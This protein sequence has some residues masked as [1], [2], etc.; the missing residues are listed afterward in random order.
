MI[1]ILTLH[2]QKLDGICKA[3]KDAVKGLVYKKAT[4][5]KY[6]YT[7]KYSD[8]TSETFPYDT[9]KD[10]IYGSSELILESLIPDDAFFDSNFEVSC[11]LLK[12]ELD[13][14]FADIWSY[15]GNKWQQV[16]SEADRCDHNRKRT[17][18]YTY[19]YNALNEPFEELYGYMQGLMQDFVFTEL[20]IRTCPYCNRQYTFTLKPNQ[21]G[22]PNT[23][24]EFD[25]FYPKS[26]YPTLAISFYNL[27]PSCHCCNHGKSQKQLYINPYEKGFQGEFCVVGKDGNRLLLNEVLSIK[28]EKDIHVGYFGPYEECEDVETLGLNQLYNMHSDYVQEVIDKVN[29]YTK[30]SV[31]GLLDSFQGVYNSPQQIYDFL[32]GKHLEL[33]E[34]EQRPLSKFTKDIL[35]QVGVKR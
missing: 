24:P 29:A 30:A 16:K 1:S 9:L 12:E 14:V 4:T 5:K 8:G 26:L 3:W 34:Q 17:C 6:S 28:D 18:L 11:G 21:K 7:Q 19:V 20:N 15:V 25:H 10:K 22:D 13:Y 32:W 23:S 27:V 2:D 35:E 33:V 31:N